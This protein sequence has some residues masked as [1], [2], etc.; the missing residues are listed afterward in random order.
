MLLNVTIIQ[1]G[2]HNHSED[3]NIIEKRR[4]VESMATAIALDP[5]QPLKRVYN[6]YAQNNNVRDDFPEYNTIRSSLQRVRSS[7]VP[8][9]PRHIADV[10]IDGEWAET[11]NG[12]PFLSMIDNNWGLAVFST[13]NNFKILNR[14]AEIYI[15]GTFKSCPVPYEQLLTIHGRFHGRLLPLVMCLL[16]TKQVGIYRQVRLILVIMLKCIF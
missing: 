4:T 13:D 5:S 14:C 12:N 2:E 1:V 7:L 15:D 8:P 11:W 6:M 10:A 9:I 16:S 3:D